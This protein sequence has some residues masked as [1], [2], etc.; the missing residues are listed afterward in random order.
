MING[1]FGFN[2]ISFALQFGQNWFA[3]SA[4]LKSKIAQIGE[5]NGRF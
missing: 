4:K 3:K 1:R 5:Q 2:C